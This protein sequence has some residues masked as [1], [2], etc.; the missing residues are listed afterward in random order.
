MLAPTLK[1][2]VAVFLRI[3][4]VSA[5]AVVAVG[6]VPVDQPM[7]VASPTPPAT[8]APGNYAAF[9]GLTAAQTTGPTKVHLTWTASSDP[10]VV[11]YNVYDVTQFFAPK[12]VKTVRAP[13]SNVTLD[14]L[15]NESAYTFRVRA[16]DINSKED[17]NTKDLQAIPYGGAI[18]ANVLSST[19]ATIVFNDGSNADSINV[20][21]STDS[22]TTY[23]LM[24][25]ITNVNSVTQT[26]I[27]GLTPGQTYVC[28]AD[29][30]IG[31]FE[32]N[33]TQTVTFIPIGQA[34]QLVFSAQPTN[35]IAGVALNTITATLLDANNNVVSAGPDANAS[36]TLGFSGTSPTTGSINGNASI[37][38]PA[39][40]GVATFTS[41]AISLA[42]AKLLNVSK[43]DSSGVTGGSPPHEHR[44]HRLHHLR[45]ARQLS[46]H[47]HRLPRQ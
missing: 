29:L 4:V 30:G 35:G 46:V 6:C 47:H 37:S 26:N 1:N 43:A 41:V 19:S 32:D 24:K 23:N 21:C 9:T 27:T 11:A 38:V 14:S 8:P 2:G 36:I 28:R 25:R 44:L 22:G 31:G 13:A 17:A 42:G 33:N 16:T 40:K 12:L 20:Y 3:A 7:P 15:S 10:T 45:R 5:L 39:S 18:S 34:T